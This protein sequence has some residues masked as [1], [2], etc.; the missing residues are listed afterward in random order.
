MASPQVEIEREL[1]AAASGEL[2]ADPAPLPP[3]GRQIYAI[4]RLL[5][6][7]ES[8]RWPRTRTEASELIRRLRSAR[9]RK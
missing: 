8:L 1:Q 2:V 9:G 4:A 6:K 3:A 7:R 5:L